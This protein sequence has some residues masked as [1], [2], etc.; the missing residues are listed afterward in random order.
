MEVCLCHCAN[1]ILFVC[2]SACVILPFNYATE[3]P[4]LYRDDSL[5]WKLIMQYNLL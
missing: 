5:P 2:P 1:A 4:S 3:K